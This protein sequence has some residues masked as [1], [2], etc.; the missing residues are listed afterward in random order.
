M[1]NTYDI[2]Y[3]LAVGA[4]A[5]F[6]LIKTSTRRKVLAAFSQRMGDV[7]HREGT[8]PA[9][10]IHAVSLG[11]I[12][13]TKMLVARLRELKPDLHIII[14]TTTDTGYARAMELYGNPANQTPQHLLLEG[15]AH[16]FT[17]IR[18]PL[19]F[20]PAVRKVLDHLRPSV[21]ALM[22]LELWP[23]FIRECA[24]RNIPVVL[25]NGRI[26]EPSFRKYKW[27]KPVVKRMLGRLS[28]V[29]AQDQN[30]ANRFI[31][32]GAKPQCVQVTGTM[33]F[34]TATVAD[35]VEGDEE[36]AAAL[37]LNPESLPTSPSPLGPRPSLP[38]R[39]W[40]CGSTGPGEE[41]LILQQFRTLL[42][43]HTRLRLIIVPRKPERFDEVAQL[44]TTA[45][46]TVLRRSE[47]LPTTRSQQ[48]SAFINGARVY[49]EPSTGTSLLSPVILG[50]TMGELRKFYSLADVVFVG[51]TLVDLGAK[52]H[53]SDMIEP[54]AL[55]KPI[56]VGTYTGNFA[57][58]MSRFR[59][60]DAIMEVAT[61]DQ[62]GETISILLSTPQQA[63]EMARKAQ[64]VV[65]NEK[66]ATERHARIL[67]T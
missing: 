16:P 47:T 30:Y 32:L 10:M 64:Q 35:R 54:A 26:T 24:N 44:I 18:Y 50:D 5:P 6:W 12:N 25:L 58:A 9:A 33:K 3:G 22:E 8:H 28:A 51:R 61:P 19:D 43:K 38:E 23:N 36:L 53:G 27:I 40:V 37:K 31:E 55:A 60:A 17:V 57:D 39:L 41:E 29:C 45:G 66:G 1:I 42:T 34:D 46:F 4:S 20:T 48:F 49:N 56:V 65:V 11:E 14:S 13:A 7:P 2:A 15:P 21:V 52:Q 62:L 63:K 59:A 67:L